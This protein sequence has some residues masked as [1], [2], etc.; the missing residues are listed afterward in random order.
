MRRILPIVEGDGDMLAV[1]TL[2]RRVAQDAGHFDIKVLP[3][4]KRGD[5]PKAKARF[6]DFLSAA[7]MEG[8]P[9]FWVMDYDCETCNDVDRDLAELGQRAAGLIPDQTIEFAFMVMEFESLF[10]ADFETLVTV[11]QDIPKNIT[12]PAAPETIRGAKEWISKARPKGLAYKLTT[13]QG[14]L[15]ARVDLIR[16]RS[17]S[18]S[19]RRFESAVL[20]LIDAAN[21]DSNVS[22][23]H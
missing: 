1:P 8:A 10:L 22:K 19:F 12:A 16:L 5:L 6:S 20:R 15:A 14:R 13:D 3:P 17:R 9:I 4:H 21:A 2:I 23:P 7:A 18:P 11:F